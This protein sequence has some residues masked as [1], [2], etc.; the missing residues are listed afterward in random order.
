M[1]RPR[2]VEEGIPVGSTVTSVRV[3]Q[4]GLEQHSH[5]Q[6]HYHGRDHDHSM[7]ESFDDGTYSCRS[8]SNNNNYSSVPNTAASTTKIHPVSSLQRAAAVGGGKGYSRVDYGEGGRM[9]GGGR[10]G[11]GQTLIVIGQSENSITSPD[12]HHGREYSTTTTTIGYHSSLEKASNGNSY[13]PPLHYSSPRPFSASAVPPSDHQDHG[14]SMMIDQDDYNYH[15]HHHHH[16]P[17]FQDVPNTTNFSM[18]TSHT[19]RNDGSHQLKLGQSHYH[20]SSSGVTP[21]LY[22]IG[23]IL[24]LGAPPNNHPSLTRIPRTAPYN[25]W[26]V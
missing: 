26:R 5:H 13:H 11:T 7:D 8:S 20:S 1:V 10:S 3:S 6:Q 14:L 22:L 16:H 17:T 21:P 12:L 2:L 18:E 19:S 4:N 23:R 15:H 24:S 9:G 25:E